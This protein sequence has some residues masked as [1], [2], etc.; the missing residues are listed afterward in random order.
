MVVIPL[1]LKPPKDVTPPHTDNFVDNTLA[2]KIGNNIATQLWSKKTKII[3]VVFLL[4]LSLV[5]TWYVKVYEVV[6]TTIEY[7]NDIAYIPNSNEPFT[8][9]YVPLPYDNGQKKAEE[10][11][12]DGNPVINEQNAPLQTNALKEL[13]GNDRP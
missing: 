7:R 2:H 12:K 3:V 4:T 6:T 5:L 9:K 8:G 13:F 10:N 1:T 11:Y